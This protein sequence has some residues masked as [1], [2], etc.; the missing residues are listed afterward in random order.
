MR[1]LLK[2]LH[3]PTYILNSKKGEAILSYFSQEALVQSK[4]GNIIP[5]NLVSSKALNRITPSK[6]IDLM[7]SEGCNSL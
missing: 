2:V 6:L 3:I 1:S 7:N 5:P 4:I